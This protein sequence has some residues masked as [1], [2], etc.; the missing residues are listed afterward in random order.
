MELQIDD[1]FLLDNHLNS[2]G[3]RSVASQ[4]NEFLVSQKLDEQ[5]D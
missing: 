4:I 5:A 2:V 1:F 3:H